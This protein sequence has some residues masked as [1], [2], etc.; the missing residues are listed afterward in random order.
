MKLYRVTFEY[1]GREQCIR[2]TEGFVIADDESR[3]YQWGV[4]RDLWPD[5]EDLEYEPDER[6]PFSDLTEEDEHRAIDLGLTLDRGTVCGP[7]AKIIQWFRG[8]FH[9]FEDTD[10]AR[11][12]WDAG[13]PI[14]E[15]EAATL[16]RLGIAEVL[17]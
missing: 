14:T 7:E 12:S 13:R 16:V 6:V 5:E 4:W 8:G 1:W 10:T 15:D 11:H 2:G 3:I 17:R 9:R